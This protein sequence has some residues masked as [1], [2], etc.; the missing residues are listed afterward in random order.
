MECVDAGEAEGGRRL[1]VADL[2][3]HAAAPHDFGEA[4]LVGDVVAGE[5]RFAPG[6]G[7]LGHEAGDGVRL[8]AAGEFQLD[9]LA[10]AQELDAPV[11]V[12]E[13]PG[14]LHAG[15][16]ELRPLA[17]VQRDGAR[18]DLAQ[19]ARI[20]RHQRRDP[21]PDPLGQRR[22][23]RDALQ[24][25]GGVA[26]L[27]PVHAPHR[28]PQRRKQ[29]VD[30]RYVAARDDG[31]RPVCGRG[32]PAQRLGDARLHPHGA[33]LVGDAGER[34][35]EI[36]EEGRGGG[37]DVARGLPRRR[38]GQARARLFRGHHGS[39]GNAPP[40]DRF[41]SPGG[42]M[43]SPR[44]RNR[45]RGAAVVG[46]DEME[47]SDMARFESRV[48][49]H[50]DTPTPR[51]RVDFIGDTGESVSVECDAPGVEGPAARDEVVEAARRLARAVVDDA[52][53][54]APADGDWAHP[55]GP[56]EEPIFP[57]W[58]DDDPVNR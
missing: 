57:A 44:G 41:P 20:A 1:A 22:V 6:E 21:R 10:A 27:Q 28:Q 7:R 36:E 47:V 58:T 3:R 29:R 24:A 19:Q 16:G 18:L 8:A 12:G 2:D 23:H 17:V 42:R 15:S 38:R 33:G 26:P 5:Q 51:Y 4:V 35:V 11:L 50:S 37:I 49:R 30:L 55:A 53:A 34:S 31:E 54:T 13:P 45:A 52:P 40:A 43:P 9:H 48:T 32:E 46:S 25:A 56:E 39:V 14:E